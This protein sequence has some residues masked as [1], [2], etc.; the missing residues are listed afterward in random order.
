M[1]ILDSVE[2][3]KDGAFVMTLTGDAGVGKT[4]LAATFPKPLFIRAED[5]LQA[6][7]VEAR[8]MALP[9]M[10]HLTTYGRS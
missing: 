3:P 5:G 7:P 9:K 6:I 2:V 10:P 1:S 4:S 8:P